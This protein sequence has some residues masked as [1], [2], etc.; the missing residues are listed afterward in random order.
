MYLPRIRVLGFMRFVDPPTAPC[1]AEA[2]A[3][4]TSPLIA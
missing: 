3:V 2:T 4:D 1:A